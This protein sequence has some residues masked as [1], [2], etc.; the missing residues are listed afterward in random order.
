VRVGLV[1]PYSLDVPGGVQ[2]HVLGLADTLRRSGH[3]VSV[4]AP[5]S[6]AGL[7]PYVVT[8]G[9]SVA[10]R[11]NGA[12][13]RMSFGPLAAARVRR[14]LAEEDLDVL[15]LHEPATPSLSLL[16][17]W[18]ADVPVVATFHSAHPGSRALSVTAPVLRPSLARLAA[19]IAVSEDSRATQVSHLG[20]QHLVIPNGLDVHRLA[21][22]PTH[23]PWRGPGG[24][25]AFVGRLDE[26]R[27]GFPVLAE[28][29]SALVESRPGV[30]LLVVGGGDVARARRRLAPSA[31]R[32]ARFLGPVDDD[33]VASVLRTADV[34][35]APHLGRES[36]GI[37]LAEA[38]AA[39]TTVLASDLPAFRR[40]L[41]DGALGTL[42]PVG[43]PAALGTAL[44]LLLDDP[45]RRAGLTEAAREAVTAY[46]WPVVGARVAQVYEAV[47]RD[48]AHRQ[49]GHVVAERAPGRRP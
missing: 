38:M 8:A 6:G 40:V 47:L 39:G 3:D 4:L 27:K 31:R 7:P 19:R 29:F 23:P 11:Y 36:F 41:R 33:G 30:R 5:G 28:A 42:V 1:C 44:D 17:L 20:G 12:V 13:A 45:G 14:W 9:R 37:V 48:A 46:D 15:H 34:F 21:T 43:D 35:V 25:V 49:R 22:A 24:T 18:A 16:A 2:N 32:A 26:P 10:V